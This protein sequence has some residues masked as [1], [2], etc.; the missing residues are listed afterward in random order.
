MMRKGSQKKD[1]KSSLTTAGG[2]VFPTQKLSRVRAGNLK[3]D[4]ATGGAG[5]W[6]SKQEGMGGAGRV[7]GELASGSCP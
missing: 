1:V 4:L 5:R 7:V 6:D 3:L 2:E